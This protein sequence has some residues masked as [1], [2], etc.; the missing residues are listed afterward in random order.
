M[1]IL[2]VSTMVSQTSRRAS[3]ADA[4]AAQLQ[5]DALAFLREAEDDPL[6]AALADICLA[7]S[8]H[9]HRLPLAQWAVLLSCQIQR[10]RG[11]AE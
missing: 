9:R 6:S 5:R 7:I 2:T 1:V 10:C 8:I 11:L 3:D 4:C